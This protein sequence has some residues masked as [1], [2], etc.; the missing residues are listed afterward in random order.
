IPDGTVRVSNLRAGQLDLIE[1]VSPQ[2]LKALRSDPN[3]RLAS[4]PELGYQVITFNVGNGPKANTPLAKDA[5]LRAA[6]DA[7]IDRRVITKVV[8]HDEFIP[9]NQ[10]V[11]PKNYFY[12]RDFPVPPRDIAKAKK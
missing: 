11:S 8:F 2:D 5:R 1:R 4:A 12:H 6:F 3:V 9:G 7:A 10:Y